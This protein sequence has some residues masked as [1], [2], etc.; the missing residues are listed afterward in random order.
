MYVAPGL[1]S[2]Q[3]PD[4]EEPCNEGGC[5]PESVCL[6]QRRPTKYRSPPLDGGPAQ[7]AVRRPPPCTRQF[8]VRQVYPR[9]L[10]AG[11][12]RGIQRLT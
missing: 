11:I 5:W 9:Y 6:H 8:V 7:H 2:A 1:A 3:M 4:T 10:I 12:A